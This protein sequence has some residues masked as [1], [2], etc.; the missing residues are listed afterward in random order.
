MKI[1]GDLVASAQSDHTLFLHRIQHEDLKDNEDSYSDNVS[2]STPPKLVEVTS[3]S[4]ADEGLFL[5]VDWDLGYVLNDVP[6]NKEQDYDETTINHCGKTKVSKRCA[7]DLSNGSSANITVSTQHGSVIV[8]KLSSENE[9]SELL[10]IRNAHQMCGESMPVWITC[11]DPHSKNILVTGGDDCMMKLW[12]IRQGDCPTHTNKGHNAG[13]TSA[14]W[15]PTDEHV[16][17]SGSYDENLR[18]WDHRVMR[19]PISEIHVGKAH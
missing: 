8:Y 1:S 3:I 9:F 19:C 4:A 5:S 16:F 15:H 6:L 10:H 2:S 7:K 11:F 18:I 12:D 14:Q 17:A 13:V